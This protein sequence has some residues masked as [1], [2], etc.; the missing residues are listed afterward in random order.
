MFKKLMYSAGCAA[1][2]VMCVCEGARGMYDAAKGEMVFKDDAERVTW[3]ARCKEIAVSEYGSSIPESFEKWKKDGQRFL[4]EDFL[5]SESFPFLNDGRPELP[6][7]LEGTLATWVFSSW[8][9]WD[10]RIVSA[11]G[12]LKSMQAIYSSRTR[13]SA[14]FLYALDAVLTHLRAEEEF[15]A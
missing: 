5:N 2:A 1:V 7:W 8:W 6:E 13:C 9:D 15:G 4:T 10:T 3:S 12:F 14:S 11:N